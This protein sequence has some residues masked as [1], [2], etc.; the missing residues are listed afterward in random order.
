MTAALIE[1]ARGEHA[2]IAAERSSL[3]SEHE[4]LAG[5]R[6][7]KS[8][9]EGERDD[10]RSRQD[11]DA[12]KRVLD[13]EGSAPKRPRRVSRLAE[14]DGRIPELAAAIRLQEQRVAGLEAE[15][16]KPNLSYVAA[17]LD[18][19]GAMQGEA[20]EGLR[21]ALAGLAPQLATIIAAGQIRAGTI[22]DRFPVPPGVTPPMHGGKVAQS[23]AAALPDWL[24][25]AELDGAALREVAS[26]ASQPIL[27]QIKGVDL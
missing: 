23:F 13:G 11:T 9:L 15:S 8:R 24:R 21:S 19:T 4:K 5:L 27:A 22:G 10:L 6:V 18:I 2:A 7:E 1:R 17:V 25:P 12:A 16:K 3:N 26:A 14:L 20:I